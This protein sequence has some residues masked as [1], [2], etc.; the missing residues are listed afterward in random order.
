MDSELNVGRAFGKYLL[1]LCTSLLVA[2]FAGLPFEGNLEPGSIPRLV[3][4]VVFFGVFTL[5][6]LW[7]AGYLS[8]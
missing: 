1:Y 5:L 3:V 7:D 6:F 4:V 8:S 2:T